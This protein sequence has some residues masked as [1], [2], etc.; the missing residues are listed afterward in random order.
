MKE[1]FNFK[2]DSLNQTVSIEISSLIFPIP[3]ILLTAYHFIGD[4]KVII[5]KG[6][7]D[8]VIVTLVTK[9]KLDESD[10]EELAYDFN[11]QLISSFVIDEKER[12]HA[13]IRETMMKAA[14]S[15]NKKKEWT[16]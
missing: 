9:Q 6:N 16:E 2:I 4:K 1:K 15:D 7:E 3:V 8:K 13:G 14:L 11:F 10:L 12:R 5:E